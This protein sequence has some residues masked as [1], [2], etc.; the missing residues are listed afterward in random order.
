MTSLKIAVKAV[1]F[2]FSRGFI[3]FIALAVQVVSVVLMLVYAIEWFMLFQI[4]STFLGLVIF[5][6]INNRKEHAEFKLP[7]TI[8]LLLFPILGSIVY[9]FYYNPKMNNKTSRYMTGLF[10]RGIKKVEGVPMPTGDPDGKYEN[11]YG[12]SQSLFKE[13]SFYGAYGNRVT[14][15]G[16]GEEFF[17]DLKER[18]KEAKEFI[19]MQFFIIT[20]S[21]M[22]NEIEEILLEKVKAGVEVR[23]MY[24]D[25]GSL[26]TP[27]AFRKRLN[28][29]GISCIK[30]NP[31]TLFNFGRYDNRDHRKIV[32]I[33]GK[34]GYTGGSNIA[35]EYINLKP[36]FGRWKDST[37]RIEGST[38]KVLTFN[39]LLMNDVMRRIDPDY[40]KSSGY[41][42]TSDYKKY[43][44]VDTETF[45]DGGYVQP[46][47]DG[48]RP[49]YEDNIAENNFL[50][51]I[52]SAKKRLY[53]ATPYLIPDFS[54]L[55]ALTLAASRGVDVRVVTPHIPD[56]KMI[57]RVTRSHYKYLHDGGVKIYE[58]TPGFIHSKQWLSDD[59]AFIGTVNFDYRSLVHHFECGVNLYDTPCIKDIE[60]DFEEI[61]AVSERIDPSKLKQNIFSKIITSVVNLFSP[62]L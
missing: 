4:I 3:P 26:R 5:F 7:W 38:V 18:L 53:I 35:D 60:K 47:V 56:K 11:S 37:V 33:D 12:I 32:I 14:Y 22:W 24:D 48:P 29:L 20:P 2:L 40:R 21:A 49:F 43:L 8:V 17:M 51:L 36:R 54:L 27:G 59:N 19:F 10:Y 50:N 13:T 16:T 62:M 28:K 15:F 57:F 9:F 44:C 1:Y 34:T 42:K 6:R 23:V 52:N 41:G 55:S 25:V 31:L 61:F 30:F 58:F 39:F 46:F 45:D